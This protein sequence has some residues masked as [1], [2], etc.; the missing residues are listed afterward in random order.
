MASTER[1]AGHGKDD[2]SQNEGRLPTLL[3]F[4]DADESCHRRL[5]GGSESE[6]SALAALALDRATRFSRNGNGESQVT[7]PGAVA[8]GNSTGVAQVALVRRLGVQ[9]PEGRS[10]E[11]ER[12]EA[13][14][15]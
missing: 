8:I 10:V 3:W 13:V 7:G 6:R 12:G 5:H 2:H 4:L 11:R 15:G 14:A 9:V 1:E